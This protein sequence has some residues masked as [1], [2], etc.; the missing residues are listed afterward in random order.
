MMS[1]YGKYGE[2]TYRQRFE[3]S[4]DFKGFNKV[5]LENRRKEFMGELAP[6]YI[7]NSG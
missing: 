2:Q 3:K 4:F 1:R 7:S 5:I 6:R